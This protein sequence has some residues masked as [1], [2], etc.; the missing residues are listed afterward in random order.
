MH[1]QD[2]NAEDRQAEITARVGEIAE[3]RAAIEQV[4]GMLMLIFG[5]DADAAFQMLR[6]QS[7]H[8]NVKLRV[9]A[10]QIHRDL[11]TASHQRAP[12][13]R[14]VYDNLV[15]TAYTR[16]EQPLLPDV[17]ARLTAAANGME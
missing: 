1:V 8:H 4:K 17:V 15:H 2:P 6:W 7:Q 5:V 3:N 9:L 10:E 11:V 14:I 13:D 16:M 12:V